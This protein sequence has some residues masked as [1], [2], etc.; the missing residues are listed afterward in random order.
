MSYHHAIPAEVPRMRTG[1]EIANARR[2]AVAF[3]KRIRSG[4]PV[5]REDVLYMFSTLPIV[6]CFGGPVPEYPTDVKTAVERMPPGTIV[7]AVF[8]RRVY[9]RWDPGGIMHGS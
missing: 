3:A 1:A 4:A 5:T 6:G 8:V 2:T 7:P 9:A